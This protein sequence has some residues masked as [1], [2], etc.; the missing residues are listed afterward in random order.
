MNLSNEAKLEIAEK[1]LRSETFKNAPTSTA[2]L[3]YLVQ[4]ELKDQVLKESI[5]D[6]EF[7]GGD[8]GSE[9]NN[10]RVRVNIFNLRKKLADYYKIEGA[11]DQFIILLEKG[12]YQ[13]KYQSGAKANNAK[14]SW[15]PSLHQGILL[16]LSLTICGL[17]F[18]YLSN[19]KPKVWEGFINNGHA[20]NL[21]IGDAFGYSGK[22]ISGLNGWT[23]D[24]DINSLDDYYKM[25]EDKPQLKQLTSPTDY[26]YSTRMAENATH[27]LARFFTLLDTDFVIK[28][29]THASFVDIKKEN[30]IYI[31][32]L[33]DQKNFLYLFNEGNRD[34]QILD[35][36]V[37]F[38][39]NGNFSDTTFMTN[40]G[41]KENDLALVS[42][43]P[44]PNDT[45]QFF[46]FS[47]HD[48]GVMA[49]VEYFTNLDSLE[50]FTQKHLM[51]NT[52]FT[53][54]FKAKGKERTNLSL[55][56]I[57]VVPF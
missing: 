29:A 25:L 13:L 10:P 45:E 35:N 34:F 54:I 24:F 53:A 2:L 1:I 37:H 23:R 3:R 14:K 18:F 20:T 48:I 9:K 28:Y 38:S 40:I 7:F 5:I 15:K 41:Y 46:F 44:G 36:Q 47:N 32:R 6:V 49:T 33:K 16:L 30:T 55:E 39:G 31:G 50:S 17:L 52:Y 12:Q 43:M 27:D 22:T 51:D 11:G 21:Y 19:T 42:R 4:A 56:E 26:N 8:P 57:L